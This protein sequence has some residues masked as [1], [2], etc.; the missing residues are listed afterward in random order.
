MTFQKFLRQTFPLNKAAKETFKVPQKITVII[1][2][3][4]IIK[5]DT[6]SLNGLKFAPD[7][8]LALTLICAAKIGSTRSSLSTVFI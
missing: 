6:N 3:N 7:C 5:I 4:V 1:K 8:N 2:K